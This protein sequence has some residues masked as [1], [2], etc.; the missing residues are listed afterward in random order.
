MNMVAMFR[1]SLL[2]LSLLLVSM[3][4]FV[5]CSDNKK[6]G[7]D[8]NLKIAIAAQFHPEAAVVKHIGKAVNNDN[9]DQFM[10]YA[11]GMKIFKS[12]I[13]AIQ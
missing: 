13:C 12:F 8:D 7:S 5:S 11:D 10:A 6:Q 1:K 4:A 2:F 9:A 3:A